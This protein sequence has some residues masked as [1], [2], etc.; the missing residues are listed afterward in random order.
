MMLSAIKT[1][2]HERKE[3]NINAVV[4]RV[5]LELHVHCPLKVV[6]LYWSVKEK[7]S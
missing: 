3:E 1:K 4:L 5:P 7:L 6:F 2:G